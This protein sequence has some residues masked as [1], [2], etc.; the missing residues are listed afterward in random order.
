VTALFMAARWAACGNESELTVWAEGV[1]G[2][3][4]FPFEIARRSRAEQ[5]AFVARGT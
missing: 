4:A 3:T 1:H 2:F 5:H